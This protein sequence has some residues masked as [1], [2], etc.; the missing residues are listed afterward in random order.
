[1]GARE[2]LATNLRAARRRQG[3]SQE[4]LAYRA[5]IDRTYVSALERGV[6]AATIDVIERIARA[7]DMQTWELLK[8]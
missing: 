7:L 5:D 8:P 3:L 4:E 6:Y 2:T 1:M